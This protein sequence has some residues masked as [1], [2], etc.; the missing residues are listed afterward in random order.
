[1]TQFG[2]ADHRC[3][4]PVERGGNRLRHFHCYVILIATDFVGTVLMAEDAA[5]GVRGVFSS[6][7]STSRQ[8]Y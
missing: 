7:S 2:H 8:I 4:V 5:G 3:F 6:L 1:M